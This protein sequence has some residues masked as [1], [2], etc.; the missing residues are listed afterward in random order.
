MSFDAEAKTWDSDPVKQE[1]ALAVA[2]DFST[3]YVMKKAT[4]QGMREYPVFLAF[5]ARR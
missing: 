4:D 2:V 5:A 1:R 3:C